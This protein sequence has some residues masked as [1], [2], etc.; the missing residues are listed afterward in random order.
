MA[1]LVKN[2][3]S[4]RYGF[5]PWVGKIPWRRERLPTPVFWPGEFDGLYRVAKSRTQLSDFHFTSLTI[6]Y[7]KAVKRV[8]LKSCHHKEKNETICGDEC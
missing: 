8:D 6:V 1:Q 3:P 5:N 2:L 7:L 4:R